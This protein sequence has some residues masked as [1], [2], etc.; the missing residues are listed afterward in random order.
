MPTL[1]NGVQAL[2]K[3]SATTPADPFAH[4]VERHR[5]AIRVR[6]IRSGHAGAA[7]D[8]VSWRINRE[9]IIVAGWARAILLQLAHP[10]VAAGVNDHSAFRGSLLSGLRRLRSTV[11]AMLALSFGDT[12]RMVGAAARINAIHDRVR[13][14]VQDG[15]AELYSAHDPD[16]LRWVHVTLLASIPL[17]YEQLIGPLTTDERD[18]YCAEAAVMEPLL[19]IPPGHLP[20]DAAQLDACMRGM[21]ASGDLAVTGTS[22]ALARAL[23]YPPQW[24]LAWPAFRPMQLMTIGSLP[25]SIRD[26]YG[27]EWRPRDARA[28][29]RWTAAIRALLRLLPSAARHWPMSRT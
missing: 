8:G 17:T 14:R 26:A 6:L 5:A 1:A 11:N 13:G 19:G 4:A 16:L 12:E 2:P 25:A 18:R 28:L 22:R 27:F 20:R 15:P 29:A 3:L 7:R 24:Y 10:S 23:L 9:V 21:L